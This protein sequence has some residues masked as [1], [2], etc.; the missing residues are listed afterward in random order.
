LSHEK[1]TWRL[2]GKLYHDRLSA[3]NEAMDTDGDACS[4]LVLKMSEKKMVEKLFA[5]DQALRQAQAVVDWLEQVNTHAER[6]RLRDY[7][8]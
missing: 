3:H 4:P 2:I 8:F 5:R 6:T 1:N 7:L